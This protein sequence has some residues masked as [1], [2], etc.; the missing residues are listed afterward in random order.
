MSWSFANRRHTVGALL[1]LGGALAA[2]S[3]RAQAPA[4]A[5]LPP[6]QLDHTEVLP[7]PSARWSRSYEA[8]I[9]LPADYASAG[10][11]YPLVV[12]SDAPY[13]FPVVRAIAGR[14]QRHGTGLE[15]FI[16]VGLS[17]AR[18]ENGA[19]SRNR[20]YTP[21]DRSLDRGQTA[22]TG[23][24]GQASAYLDF[25]AQDVLPLV[26]QRYRTQPGRRVYVG[27][28]YGSLL[29]LQA[30]QQQPALFSHHILGSPSLWFN[31][32]QPFRALQAFAPQAAGRSARLRLYVGGLERPG[33]QRPRDE[34]MVGQMKRYAQ[35]LQALP[36]RQL[37]LKA[38]VL[39]GEDHAT[40]FPRLVTA[41]LAWALPK[42][43]TA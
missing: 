2:P 35:A 34:D 28:S 25:L 24:Y 15:D 10:R 37:D 14:V 6:Y 29:G 9:G 21:T 20:D 42:P 3:L 27:H 8:Y 4:T 32:G 23:V 43:G 19:V 13:A 38:Q 17:Y 1:G 33:P 26:D 18:G 7:T 39:D 5:T 30:L 41:G 11:R 40:V 16:L 22:A 31:G 12:V 36:W